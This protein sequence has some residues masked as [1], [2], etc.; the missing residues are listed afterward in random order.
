MQFDIVIGL[1]AFVLAVLPSLLLAKIEA[2]T[3]RSAKANERAADAA[4]R[5]SA[6]LALA[7]PAEKR[8]GS[9][10]ELPFG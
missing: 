1:C 5:T 7:A 6:R 9:R 8:P 2:N 10:G 3:R 4:E